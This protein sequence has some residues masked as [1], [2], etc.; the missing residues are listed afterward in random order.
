MESR[1]PTEPKKSDLEPFPNKLKIDPKTNF[2]VGNPIIL[3]S[4]SQNLVKTLK[5]CLKHLKS[6]SPEF[7]KI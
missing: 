4:K 6:N 7:D 2:G 1:A 5:T 3:L